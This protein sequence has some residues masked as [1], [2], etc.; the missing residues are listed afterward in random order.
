M[1]RHRILTV[2]TLFICLLFSVSGYSQQTVLDKKISI[3]A[4]HKTI[5]QVLTQIEQLAGVNFMYMSGLFD[6]N[7]IVSIHYSNTSIKTI[8]QK[9]IPSNTILL[10]VIDNKII[11]YKKDE[12]PPGK[13][14]TTY[15]LNAPE[16]APKQTTKE[17][18]ETIKTNT[19]YDTIKV[20]IF[21]TVSITKYDTVKIV[22]KLTPSVNSSAVAIKTSSS[23]V[24]LTYAF[25]GLQFIHENFTSNNSANTSNAIEMAE[26]A[27]TSRFEYGIGIDFSIKQFKISTGI[28]SFEK[29]WDCSYFH[30]S[31]YKN[32]N[33]IIGYTDVVTYEY[34]PKKLHGG[35]FI[36]PGIPIPISYDTT[37]I[38]TKTPIYKTDTSKT[39]YSGTNKISYLSIPFILSNSFMLSKP[40]SITV[41]IG[42][43]LTLLRSAQGYSISDSLYS[44]KPLSEVCKDYYLNSD[45]RIAI[46]YMLGKH[47]YAGITATYSFSI[48]SIFKESYPAIRKESGMSSFISIGWKW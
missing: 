30:I 11:F 26:K 23:V 35:G 4:S 37:K 12:T 10:Y 17:P 32:Y 33:K 34:T 9:I 3:K 43:N 24:L 28:N 38:I 39:Q 7:K 48:S 27:K 41:G 18:A 19:I 46:S 29:Q 1:K 31:T 16:A 25:S 2:S 47:T 15:S 20:K 21:D 6:K 42:I 40:L 45:N 5:A 22:E 8:L 13:E 44:L 14:G 36:P